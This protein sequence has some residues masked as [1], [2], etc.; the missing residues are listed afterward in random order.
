MALFHVDSSGNM[1]L[2]N[3]SNTFTSSAPF[4]VESDGTVKAA[5]GSIGG[6]SINSGDLQANYSAS[7]ETGF[8]IQSNGDAYFNK[9]DVRIGS[10][11][12]QNPSTGFTTLDIG[13][14]KL[15]EYNDDLWISAE[16]VMI[17]DS[18][19]T[20]SASSPSL[21]L[22]AAYGQPGWYVD[23]SQI[24]RTKLYYSNGVNNVFHTESD[25][26]YFHLESGT[27]GIKI[28]TDD[29]G[30]SQ[31]IGKNSSGTFGWHNLPTG[32]QH[33]DSD[34]SFLTQSDAD[35]RY[36]NESDHTHSNLVGDTAFNNHANSSTAH[37]TF[38]FYS[39][40]TLRGNPSG[41][42]QTSNIGSTG[43]VGIY[44][45]SNM[46]ASM[47]GSSI[48]LSASGI[49][50]ISQSGGDGFVKSVSGSTVNTSSILGNIAIYTG[51][52]YP[53]S[54][55]N[56]LGASNDRWY[57]LYAQVSTS[58]SSDERLKEN[59]VDI[60]QGLDFINDLRP[61]EFTWKDVTE[62]AC[63][64]YPD[65]KYNKTRDFCTKCQKENDSAYSNY[66]LKK[67]KFDNEL[68]E[69]EP[70]EP[71]FTACTWV[72]T[73]TDINEGKKSW[74]M[75]AQEVETTLGDY[76]GQVLNHDT[77]NDVY[78]LSYSSFVAPIIKAV[79]ELSTQVSDLTARIE[80]LEG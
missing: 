45:G 19:S 18:D 52:H 32:N 1:W 17:Y 14:A 65:D 48:T 67:E 12:S 64:D 76:D 25:N 10:A 20:A 26:T 24:N 35:T 9:V 54:S 72:E 43:A 11:A 56:N 31:Y 33:P 44:A 15:S 13:T 30:N 6:I 80:A 73:T 28:G 63:E 70:T 69:D 47:S 74:G 8:K 49:Q 29:G 41:N 66:L 16:R 5:S 42:L 79:Q 50:S 58:V 36:V 2:G 62:Y 23:D 4:Y 37:G 3:T 27:D 77:V 78:G 51:S 60:N 55:F 22:F 38:D 34:H 61:V 39:Y 68:I 53:E 59:I 7:N 57:R 46:S 40:W 21:F 71:T 75:I